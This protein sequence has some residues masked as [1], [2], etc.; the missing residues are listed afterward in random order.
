MIAMKETK[1]YTCPLCGSPNVV[2]RAGG[3]LMCRDCGNSFVPKE[4]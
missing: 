3:S 1:K 4:V 2:M